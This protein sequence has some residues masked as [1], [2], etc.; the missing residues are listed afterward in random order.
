MRVLKEIQT[1]AAKVSIFSFNEKWIVK[2]EAG[3]CEQTYKFQSEEFEMSQ[4]EE[5][6]QKEAFQ[7]RVAA[8]FQD[9]HQEFEN[10]FSE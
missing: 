8:R 9:M 2:C 4:V 5:F 6:C 10:I 3:F 1:P 7:K